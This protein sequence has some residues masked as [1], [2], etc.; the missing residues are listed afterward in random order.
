MAII[1]PDALAGLPG[2]DAG[3]L[4]PQATGKVALVSS[5]SL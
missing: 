4:C 3:L 5:L 1:L 2:G